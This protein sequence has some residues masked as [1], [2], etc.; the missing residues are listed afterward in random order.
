MWIII[1]VITQ[2]HL[3]SIHKKEE[4]EYTFYKHVLFV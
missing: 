1:K 3:E 2:V 4:N